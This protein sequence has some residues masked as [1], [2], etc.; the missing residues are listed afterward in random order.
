MIRNWAT[1]DFYSSDCRWSAL[2]PP[3]LAALVHPALKV[4]GLD[5]FLQ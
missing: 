3:K 1:P 2:N 5:S 4:K